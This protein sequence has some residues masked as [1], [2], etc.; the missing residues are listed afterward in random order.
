MIIP[1][2]ATIVTTAKVIAKLSGVIIQLAVAKHIARLIALIVTLITLMSL[3]LSYFLIP[4]I[5][6]AQFISIKPT[7]PLNSLA[8]F[9]YFMLFVEVMTFSVYLIQFLANTINVH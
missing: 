5:H 6:L 9:H 8:N 4:L 7:N 1:L 2:V 3:L